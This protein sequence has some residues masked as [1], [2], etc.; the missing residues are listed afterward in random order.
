MKYIEGNVYFIYNLGD[1]QSRCFF[2]P[3]H[4]DFFIEKMRQYLPPNGD[5]LAFTL[6]PTAFYWLI[7]V[8]ERGAKLSNKAMPRYSGLPDLKSIHVQQNLSKDIGS[9]LSSYTKAINMERR[10]R[11]SLFKSS[12]VCK[13]VKAEYSP[14]ELSYDKVISLMKR[15]PVEQG[16]VFSADAYPYCWVGNGIYH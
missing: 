13:E 5:V 8:N 1:T 15:R 14:G 12:T 6:L 9:L 7:R 16:L 2:T 3:K 10:R 11:G 4:Y